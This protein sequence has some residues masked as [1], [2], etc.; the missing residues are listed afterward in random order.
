MN[1]NFGQ[2]GNVLVTADPRA[3]FYYNPLN[4]TVTINLNALDQTE[5]P[6]DKYAIVVHAGENGAPAVL[7]QAGLVLDGEYNGFFFPTG[8]GTPGGPFVQILG[9]LT[10]AAPKVQSVVLNPNSDSGIKG[11]NN[12]DITTPVF[13]GQVSA[14]FPGSL[15]GLT[16][17]A[18]FNSL[19]GGTN[20][21]AT[22]SNGRGFVG[23]F[24]VQ[25]TTDASGRFVIQAPHLPEGF[26]D[27]R[28]VVIANP[29]SPPQAGFSSSSDFTFR[30]DS[31]TPAVGL[32]WNG[33]PSVPLVAVSLTPGGAPLPV[34]TTTNP[35]QP[36]Q[37][38]NLSSLST[39]SVDV[40][41][42]S[43][44]GTG[45]L[46]T[47]V[48]LNF[49]AV[50][51]SSASNLSNYQLVNT[52]T[53][54]NESQF[55][56]TAAF[57]ATDTTFGVGTSPTRANTSIPYAGRVDLTFLPGLPAGTYAFVVN[58]LKD[59]AGNTLN[60]FYQQGTR[61]F[62]FNFNLQPAPV[63]ITS[64][65]LDSS[66]GQV[67]G[68]PRS[69][70]E[71]P[72][73]G[74]TANAPAPPTQ[75]VIDV[76]TPLDPTTIN[77]NSIQLIGSNNGSF[78][79]LGEGGLGSSGSG[80]T[81]VAGTT[82]TLVDPS[83]PSLVPGDAGFIGTRLVMSLP[84]GTTLPAN[85]YRIYMPNSDTTVIKDIYGN[86]LDGEFLG[87]L[88]S[89]N[90]YVA[91]SS[92]DGYTASTS[93]QGY[94][95]S[96]N[97][98]GGPFVTPTYEDLQANGTYRQ[99]DV[100]GDGF[101]GGAFMTAFDVAPA[102]NVIYARPGYVE[103]PL[104]PS[105]YANGSLSNPY[106][107]LAPQTVANAQ[108]G[109]NLNAAVNFTLPFN[110]NYDRAALGHFA[111]SAIYAAQVLSAN[112]P[113]VIVALPG[114]PQADP[115]TGVVTTPS[116][117]LQA[118]AGSDSTI[119]DAS[120]SLPFDTMMVFQPG[121]DVKLLNA[122]ILV[123]NQGTALQALGTASSSNH[124]IFTS[125]NDST[126]GGNSNNTGSAPQGSDWGGIAFRNYN[127]QVNGGSFPIDG[128]LQGPSGQP[129]IS[130]ADDTLS[131][132]NYSEIRYAGGAV[133]QT[134]GTRYD[135]ITLSNSRPT[136]TNDQ[137]YIPD[138][139]T[140]GAQATISGDL[141]S[142]R[143]DDTA[144]GP[145]IR[146][147]ST[148][149][150]SLNGIYVRANLTTGVTGVAEATN[151]MTYPVNP[152]TL[153][154]NIN[155]EFDDPLP[156]ILTSQLV[157]G[158]QTLVNTGGQTQFVNNRLYV[159]PG[160]VV[161]SNTGAGIAVVNGGQEDSTGAIIANSAASINIGSHSYMNQFDANPSFNSQT[162]GFQSE[163]MSDQPVIFTSLYDFAARTAY[164]PSVDSSNDNGAKQP[165]IGNASD[166]G[167]WGGVGIQGGAVAV[168][169]NATFKFGGG[170]VNSPTGTLPSQSVLAFIIQQTLFNTPLT[171][172]FFGS[173]F[174]PL[175]QQGTKAI[176]TNNNFYDNFDTAMQIE[177]N[178]LL[179][180]DPTRPLQSGEPFFRGN[181]MQNNDIDGMAVVTN[182]SYKENA[183]YSQL[184]RPQE[185]PLPNGT[186]NLTVNSV[187]ASTDLTYVLRGTVV[188]AGYY[189]T[190]FRFNRGGGPPA[191]NTTSFTAEL[192]PD[193]TLTLQSAL[194]GT[195]LADGSTIAKP[196]ESLIVKMLND[197]APWD[198]G[199]TGTYGST[200]DSNVTGAAVDGG[201]GFIVGVDDAID[202]PS[203]TGSPTVDPGVGSQIRIVGIAGNQS[204]GQQR[205]PVILTS[206][207][208]AT[209]GTTVRN[210]KMYNIYNNDPLLNPNNTPSYY[211]T[212]A[213][214]DAGYIYFGGNS[215]TSYNLFD[216][217]GG[218]IID[219][220][221]IRYMTSIQI[222]SGAIVYS[223]ATGTGFSDPYTTKLG[224]TPATQYNSAFAMTISDSN[225]SY[226][227]DAAVFV[228]PSAG[229]AI[230]VPVT[231]TGL[232]QP[233]RITTDPF[234]GEGVALFMVN[235]TIS[236]SAVGVLANSDVK[237]SSTTVP[238]P[239]SP[240]E[241]VML[242]NTF[243]NDVIGQ[244]TV[245]PN[246]ASTI[247]L[248]DSVYWVSMDN[249]FANSSNTA[250][251]SDGQEYGSQAQYDLY[252]K[253]GATL[254]A[255]NP[256]ANFGGN[257][258]AIFGNPEFVN[259]AAGNFQ[260]LAN[261]AAIN[262]ARSEFGPNLAG[263][264]I[265]P[266]V[267][268]TLDANGGTRNVIGR[269][270]SSVGF[271]SVNDPR[272]QMTLPGTASFTF[273][274]EWVMALPGS[275]G[276][277]PGPASNAGTYW[278]A[279]IAGERDLAG[280]FRVDDPAVPIVGFGT[281]P[282]FAIGAY[283]FVAYN[284]PEVVA[285]SSTTN[286][287]AQLP[288]GTT[289]NLYSVGGVAGVNQVPNQIDIKFNHKLNLST[290]TSNT[291][292]LVGSGG[293][294]N[295]TDNNNITYSLNGR[296]SLDA[297]GLVIIINTAGMTL[298][299]DEYEITL[300]GT[301]S[302][303][304]Q[305]IQGN[306][307]N[308]ANTGNNND[309]NGTQLPLPS[310][311]SSYPP[312][313]NFTLK[314]AVDTHAPSIVAGSLQMATASETGVK[315]LP[316]TNS[317][318]PSFVG[319]ITDVFPPTNP[320]L[321]DTV[322]LDYLNPTTG[323]FVT[324]GQST[325]NAAG[326]FTVQAST[327]L[328]N[329]NYNVG[330]D[331]LLGT[332]DDQNY[333]VVRVRVV[334]LSGNASNSPSDPL[335]TYI[336][337]GAAVGFVVDTTPP[338]LTS[339]ISPVPN[340]LVQGSPV[341]VTFDVS[342]TL[343]PAS[344][345]AN[346]IKLVSAGPDGI[347]NTGDDVNVPLT[348]VTFNV[349]PL[350][351]SP[352][353]PEQVTF[354]LPSTLTNGLYQIS[355]YG[356]GS[357][358]ITDVA[359]NAFNG[360]GSPGSNVS[361]DFTL[362]NP[363]P[364]SGHIIYA[365][366]AGWVTDNTQPQGTRENP[367]PSIS[368]AISAA[369]VGDIVGVLPGTYTENLTLRSLVRVISAS[370]SSTDS[371]FQPGIA[372]QTVIRAPGNGQAVVT[373][374]GLSS[375]TG[376]PTELAGVTIVS[377][378]LGDQN[379]GAID[380]NSIGV[381][382]TNSKLVLDKNIIIDAGM[383]VLVNASGSSTGMP[384]VQ[385]NLIA[386]SNYGVVVNDLGLSSV[387]NAMD[388][389]NNTIVDNQVGVLAIV[390]SGSPYVA[391][392]ANNIFYANH[393]LT[394]ARNGAA[395]VANAP[396][397]IKLIS[398]MFS[399]NGASNA[400]QGASVIN[401]GNGFNGTLTTTPD[402]SGNFVGTPGFVSPYDPRPGADGPAIF[403]QSENYNLTLSSS[404]I[405]AANEGFAP[406]Y[407]F[408]YRSRVRIS[409]RGFPGTGPADVGAYEYNGTGGL[410]A[411]IA[412]RVAAASITSSPV[413]QSSSIVAASATINPQSSTNGIVVS[414][415]TP[416]NP[417]SVTPSDLILSGNG[418]S[419][420]NPAHATSL[421]WI[422]SQTVEFLLSGEFNASGT[423]NVSIPANAV[424]SQFNA[425]VP[426][427]VN[428]FQVSNP[429]PVVTSTPAPAAAV[430]TTPAVTSSTTTT[431][432]TTTSAPVQ[433]SLA[434]APAPAPVA[435]HAATAKVGRQAL[436]AQVRA[437]L[438]KLRLST[439]QARKHG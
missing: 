243:Y 426:A 45:P 101:A 122:S 344:L 95:S 415:T 436:L 64:V 125:Y 433:A 126:V 44:P 9:T 264:A 315:G 137:I 28:L 204:T 41:D 118:P 43:N 418:L 392:V 223:D 96:G 266:V 169:N 349:T 121:A 188:L 123:Q 3:N 300:K 86:Q 99:N 136:I 130:G 272:K 241:L 193:I 388:I 237:A 379:S 133:P 131:L 288:D 362:A 74:S 92:F 33:T 151:A 4:N 120:I 296:V 254:V 98:V 239:T 320:V 208:D 271:F 197:Y 17:L 177:P 195:V 292:L 226:F 85:Y 50:D 306:A 143:V 80:F 405:D 11:D 308:G 294:G 331:G 280:Q 73:A 52:T 215:L 238:D 168:V 275:P 366:P 317:T 62:T 432:A 403:F 413:V 228:H 434:P 435:V 279:P 302:N 108:N 42:P 5:L 382:I 253:N 114:I 192:K 1:N 252:Y 119:N 182:R 81:R 35:L 301:G 373:A 378:L 246:Q 248:N 51:P 356:A 267:N 127:E 184:L 180:A 152:T 368:L 171:Q 430:A 273:D 225:L 48:T 196:G 283:Q 135:A 148:T 250:I 298:P 217:R 107:V 102:G 391:D 210:V 261:S 376:L 295:F 408:L 189:D 260:L 145:L 375:I 181:V 69:Y 170:Y 22:G 78:G 352:I 218:N 389:D 399:S 419:S 116:F 369:G 37:Y 68:G 149:N 367:F 397:K 183:D 365:G 346:S 66:S 372:Q 256:T 371:S 287:Q 269:N 314:F 8:N 129:A 316:I 338:A 319:T 244:H 191:P 56:A 212:P 380:P 274:S 186:A 55:I 53:G 284:P 350:K 381:F 57:T 393:D 134:S 54:V 363:A 342:K 407:D 337:E 386:G 427:Y 198:A 257:N 174:D 138:G 19:H 40:V 262:A 59:A 318:T 124:V 326:Q 409:G 285:Y 354:T 235:N 103:N 364:T 437:R 164:T 286:V 7:D 396:N 32:T 194:P 249:I 167:L 15:A 400:N 361:W 339:V 175:S 291:V 153:G 333:S 60:E 25:T 438:A 334:D 162:A 370:S 47:P 270:V 39:L 219:N 224:I 30:I 154:G 431:A 128:T 146:N 402:A 199:N 324:V 156:Y 58:G 347:L 222:Q 34:S 428:S 65:N 14:S 214:G 265:Y 110:S 49:P 76:S 18:E 211:T 31:S 384:Y 377:P 23:N 332:S 329:T 236:N 420:S 12:T 61:Q 72:A 165:T 416:I 297:T 251:L 20:N 341:T 187:W 142:F 203:T 112:G 84:A 220:A 277:V 79:Q 109:G 414:F 26:T 13:N 36:S 310:G 429:A 16:V 104:D 410:S 166:R 207:K 255:N 330:P 425:S 325:T 351:T 439:R 159:D 100:S 360:S 178:G 327:P 202:P 278:Y 70:F 336:S 67:V 358:P 221:D 77:N 172:S 140:N 411:S 190:G 412:P 245:A 160:I 290:V 240:I 398:N 87:N 10:L 247:P 335:S 82:V 38:P 6:T 21:L 2:P 304:I 309:P 417:G 106:P 374:S 421:N 161:K 185:V 276:A 94:D 305:D 179:A 230:V 206:L 231:T 163:G 423:V 27:M 29:D 229:A 406:S 345:N 282:F 404:A 46:A 200:G 328:P 401:V 157:I 201:A 232:G 343:N 323:Q 383:G 268:Q 213:A 348:G 390:N 91:N 322:Y 303:V 313:S 105:T 293:D 289:T 242:N 132:L 113:V 233:A 357:T 216:P 24:D 263:D 63:Y 312:G 353:G 209:V 88:T 158:E 97:V 340:S 205:V 424:Q 147:T 259:A 385:S 111:S 150:Y 93:F 90:N 173:L 83:N 176:V 117:V 311:S 234:E 144:R 321:G 155:Y 307:L 75:V 281:R 299:T 227:S 355:L 394:S 141:D 139:L 422:D 89:N 258:G 387:G 359:G 115:V 395:V 71:L